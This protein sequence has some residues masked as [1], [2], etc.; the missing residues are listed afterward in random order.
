MLGAT[1][2]I[3]A[4][5]SS[6]GSLTPAGQPVPKAVRTTTGAGFMS[7]E[8][9]R[10]KHL[11]YI[12]DFSGF[13]VEI[14]PE[15]GQNQ[16][17]IG[18]ITMRYPGALAVAKNGDLFVSASGDSVIL[19]FHKGS[20]EP[21]ETL[22]GGAAEGLAFDSAGNLY[23]DTGNNA[24]NV[25]APGATSTSPTKT[26]YDGNIGLIAGGDA[27]TA[28][29][30]VFLVGAEN[31]P[32]FTPEVDEFPAG[33]SNATKLPI[34]LQGNTDMLAVD[35]A[36]D[37]IVMDPTALTV[38]VYAPPYMNAP[39]NTFRLSGGPRNIAVSKNEK[40]IWIANDSAASGKPEGQK[41][42]A[43]TGALLDTTNTPGA[44]SAVAIAVSPSHR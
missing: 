8:A 21:F 34:V 17:P 13:V 41:Y 3:F 11:L 38:S 7:P 29:G 31:G 14:Y 42:Q 40:T 24:V 25:Y 5:C 2:C 33:S 32:P 36:N 12:S 10:G 27:A 43:T 19:A 30:D 20:T 23:A 16:S 26:L 4:G 1:A 37:L 39:I 44:Q 22:T 35:D 9:K 18:E 6:P 15:H 28:G